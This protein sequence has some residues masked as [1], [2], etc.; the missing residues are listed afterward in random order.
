[1]MLTFVTSQ[2]EA[3]VG[4]D[5]S[6]QYSM[7]TCRVERI[8]QAANTIDFPVTTTSLVSTRLA[9]CYVGRLVKRNTVMTDLPLSSSAVPLRCH[10]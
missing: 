1:M 5:P 6:P 7:P 2:G 3:I 10:L 9:I 4:V 8:Q